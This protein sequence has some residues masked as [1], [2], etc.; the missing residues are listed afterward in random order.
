[1]RAPGVFVTLAALA[2][3]MA[4]E[5]R[6]LTREGR[7]LQQMA[8]PPMPAGLPAPSACVTMDC[9]PWPDIIVHCMPTFRK[10]AIERHCLYAQVQRSPHRPSRPLRRT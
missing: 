10:G 5:A 2:C 8:S 9:R 4:A 7:E 3:A 1:M 6:D